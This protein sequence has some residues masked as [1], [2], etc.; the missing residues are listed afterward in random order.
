L[1]A[2]FV[3]GIKII[4]VQKKHPKEEEHSCYEVKVACEFWEFF[5]HRSQLMHKISIYPIRKQVVD[6][7]IALYP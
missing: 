4:G 2:Q 7:N 6:F 3:L 1:T 5:N